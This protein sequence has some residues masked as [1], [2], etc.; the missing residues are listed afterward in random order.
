MPNIYDPT[1]D[2]L[3]DHPGFRAR[4]ARVGRQLGT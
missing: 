4:P 3:R 2:E 1:Y